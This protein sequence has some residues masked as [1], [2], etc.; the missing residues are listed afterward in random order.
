M[1][2]KPNKYL[3]LLEEEWITFHTVETLY[4]WVFGYTALGG[5]ET[6][7]CFMISDEVLSNYMFI[8]SV[9]TTGKV[10]SFCERILWGE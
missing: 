5:T 10:L 4:D 3:V 6:E 7:L 1:K 9:D 8:K 2:F